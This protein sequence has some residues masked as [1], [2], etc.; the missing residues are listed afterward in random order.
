MI[1]RD[2]ILRIIEEFMQAL[3]RIRTLK[4]GQ[5]WRAA[6]A[7]LDKEFD[8]LVGGGPEVVAA[9]SET[10]LLARL[11]Q[12]ESTHIVH[13]KTLMLVSL[14]KEAGDLFAAQEKTDESRASFLKGLRLLLLALAG[15]EAHDC[16]EFVPKVELFVGV[17]QDDALPLE[18]EALL[19]Q[20][21]ERIGEYAKAE[22]A[23]FAMLELEP[24]NQRIAEFGIA[25][26]ER[27]EGESD[28]RLME[29]NLP[30][31]ELEAGMAEL[32]QRIGRY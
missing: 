4:Q 20:H 14:L 6:G 30:R 8:R 11:V 16:P 29:G 31:H 12:G 5:D 7:E 15:Q 17:L 13:E 3:S 2:Y 32:R 18:T 24:N 19:M 28:T 25:F 27:L 1:R 10:E 21:F 9:L 26:Y 23:L 22:D